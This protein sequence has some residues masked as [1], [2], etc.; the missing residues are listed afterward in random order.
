MPSLTRALRPSQHPQYRVLATALTA[1]LLGA[2]VW[3]VAMVWQVMALGGG[4]TQLSAV[5][6]AGSAGL[7]AAVL[8]GG[9][10]ADRVP[11]RRVLMLVELTKARAVGTGGLLQVGHLVP[12]ARR[13]GHLRAASASP[14]AAEVTRPPPPVIRCRLERRSARS[15]NWGSSPTRSTLTSPSPAGTP[16]S[17]ACRWSRCA[18]STARTSSCSTTRRPTGRPPPSRSWA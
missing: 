1:S 5:A 16:P 15:W 3:S 6:A 8:L 17:G 18:T 12:A 9:A 13:G 14:R 11:Q 4:P 7:L 2:G 10:V